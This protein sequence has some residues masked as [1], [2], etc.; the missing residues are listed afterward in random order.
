MQHDDTYPCSRPDLPYIH[1]QLQEAQEAARSLYESHQEPA[2]AGAL[3]KALLHALVEVT[4]EM[5][6]LP[7]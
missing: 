4:R 7:R 5:G 6:K 3:Y 2:S 1:H